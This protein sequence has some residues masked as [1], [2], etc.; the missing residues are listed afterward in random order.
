MYNVSVE[1]IH[2]MLMLSNRDSTTIT[3]HSNEAILD[4]VQCYKPIGSCV[5]FKAMSLLYGWFCFYV[6]SAYIWIGN[7]YV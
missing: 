5:I 6:R 3:K 4:Y 1:V 2:A 7:P